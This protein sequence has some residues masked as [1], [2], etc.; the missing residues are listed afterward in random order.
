MFQLFLRA[1]DSS[2][3][4]SKYSGVGDFPDYCDILWLRNVYLLRIE[5]QYKYKYT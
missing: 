4:K 1:Y 2:E 3:G 5:T